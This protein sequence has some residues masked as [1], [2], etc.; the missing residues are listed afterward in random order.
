MSGPPDG[1]LTPDWRG[2]DPSTELR[3]ESAA[4][5]QRRMQEVISN[6]YMQQAG[7]RDMVMPRFERVP[8]TSATTTY[9]PSDWRLADAEPQARTITF[10]DPETQQPVLTIREGRLEAGPGMSDEYITQTLFDHMQ[11]HWTRM[12]HIWAATQGYV[13]P[14]GDR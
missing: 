5:R 10:M 4:Q 12:L 6:Y 8:T 9:R 2:D 1:W 13:K 11:R 14:E 3:V 7:Q